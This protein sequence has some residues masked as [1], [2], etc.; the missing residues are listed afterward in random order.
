MAGMNTNACENTPC[1]IP[2]AVKQ[3]YA[4]TLPLSK[5]FPVVSVFA[6]VP[7]QNPI[8]SYFNKF[9]FSREHTQ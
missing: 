7:E 5:K 8:K 4:Y 1:P 9:N 3:T 6:P 2:N